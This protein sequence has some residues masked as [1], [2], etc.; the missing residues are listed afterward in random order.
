MPAVI[1]PKDPIVLC[2]ELP[3]PSKIYE[4]NMEYRA[5][6]REAGGNSEAYRQA[7]MVRC[8]KDPVFFAD[9]FGWTQ[10]P[11]DC[12]YE[13]PRYDD[14]GN[15]LDPENPN[16]PIITWPKQAEY[17]VW[18][19][20]HI[21]AGR[22]GVVPKS[23][24]Q[25][26]TISTSLEAVRRWRF[27]RNANMLIGSRKEDMV[28]GGSFSFQIMPKMDYMLEHFPEWMLPEGFRPGRKYRNSLLIKNPESDITCIGEATSEFMGVGG[29]F[30][31]AWVDESSKIPVMRGAHTAIGNTT[32]CFIYTFTPH[33]WE[34][35][36]EL[37]HNGNID[38]FELYWTYNPLWWPK[39]FT[40]CWWDKATRQGNWPEKWLCKAGECKIHREGGMPHSERYDREC[41]K[42]DWDQ[43][44]VAQELDICYH[45]S[46]NNVFDAENVQ[47]T[48]V[49]LDGLR[50]K[51]L[52]V[53]DYYSFEFDTMGQNTMASPMDEEAWYR[54]ASRWK[55]KANKVDNSLFR[56]LRGH[57]PFTCRNKLCVCEGT[58]RH[59]YSFG[60][61]VAKGLAHGDYSAG[62]MLDCTLG[63]VIGEF[64]GHIS[65]LKLGL[66]W[67][68]VCKWFGTSSG[69]T[70][71]A[72]AAPEWNENGLIVAQAMDWLG[73]MLHRSISEDQGAFKRKKY[74]GVML[75]PSN[76]V[77]FI[78]KYLTPEISECGPD[79]MPRLA[80]P[81]PELWRELQ[82]FVNE[83]P[84]NDTTIQERPKYKGQGKCKDDRVLGLFHTVYGAKSHFGSIRRVVAKVGGGWEIVPEKTKPKPQ[85]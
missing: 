28:D 24:E 60:G 44:T 49:F 31:W 20:K 13:K 29:R 15:Q 16:I 10:N 39:G 36:A 12:V 9:G 67:A 56:I 41:E 4:K 26:V 27:K 84:A 66:I 5:F 3:M 71:D 54:A 53:Y 32:N 30:S 35:C 7:I 1:I 82:T 42:Y 80:A 79:G 43:R 78:D 50:E 37:V 2:D 77:R 22:S 47:K 8:E 34:F 73:I 62:Y 25:A 61:D 57:E 81:F 14:D 6:L 75:S 76:K 45:K 38:V 48:I 85:S 63:I 19:D 17:L 21:T 65:P 68:Q 70:M 46:G 51:G 55:V 83:G 33:G 58:G 23:R 74:L 72:W 59:V 52:P 18:L 11:K 40:G 69:G 64:H